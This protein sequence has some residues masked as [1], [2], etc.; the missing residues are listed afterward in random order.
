MRSENAVYG[1]EM[2]AHH[3]FKDFSFCDSGMIPWLLVMELVSLAGKPL[4]SLMQERMDRFPISGEIN[5]TVK[6]AAA[7]MKAIEEKYANGGEVSK[8]DGFSVEYENWRFNLRLSNTEPV[9]RLNVEVRG[10]KALLA[11]KTGELLAIIR[12]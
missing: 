2:S 4:S 1:G 10:D 8:V 12:G 9:T 6:D 3:Y 5:S 7:V 11:A